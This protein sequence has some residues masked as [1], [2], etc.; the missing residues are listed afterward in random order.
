M[1]GVVGE[2]GLVDG[3]ETPGAPFVPLRSE[4]NDRSAKDIS[5]F[6]VST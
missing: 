4:R 6:D 3:N 5:T 1:C 2:V